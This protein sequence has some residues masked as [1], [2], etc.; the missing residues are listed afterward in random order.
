MSLNILYQ[1]AGLTTLSFFVA[2]ASLWVLAQFDGRQKWRQSGFMKK[3]DSCTAFIFED[4]QIVD[5]T[6]SARQLLA[7]APVGESDWATLANLLARKFP[8]LNEEIEKLS[9][10]GRLELTATSGVSKLIATMRNGILRLELCQLTVEDEPLHIDQKCYDAMEQELETLRATVATAPFLVWRQRQDGSIDWANNSYLDLAR[11]SDPDANIPVWP[12]ANLFAIVPPDEGNRAPASRRLTVH[13]PGD[14][15]PR[16]FECS[17]T[18]L[19]DGTLFMAVAADKVVSA[20]VALRD[21]VQTLTKT[22]AHLKIGLAIFDKQRRLALFNPALTDLTSLP[23]DFLLRQPTLRAV[24]DRLRDK[25][26]IPEQRD[27]KSWRQRLFDLETAAENGTYEETWSLPTGQTYRITGRPHPDGAL[28]FLMEDISA[29]VSL[30]RRFRLELETGQTLIDT[31]EEAVAVFSTSGTLTLSNAAYSRLWG[32]E[33]TKA[34]GVTDIVEAS[35]IWNN[36]CAPSPAWADVRDFIGGMGE[37]AEWTSEVRLCDGRALFCRF[38]PL[39]GGS[40]LAGFTFVQGSISGA[41]A[42][43]TSG[44]NMG[45]AAPML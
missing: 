9:E 35:R 13:L 12:P 27:Y 2:F 23:P 29:E 42:R 3:P 30:T 41:S 22:F 44:L 33:A 31:L 8:R 24:L 34:V 4:Q 28:A 16:W 17:Q 5:A 7:P 11:R 36:K 26:M 21:F 38:T 43:D 10:S 20:E 19:E 39:A 37:R 32:V 6:K 45:T 40:T 18:R 14:A 1:L 15:E 25:R